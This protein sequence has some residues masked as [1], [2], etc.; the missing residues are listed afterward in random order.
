MP[1]SQSQAITIAREWLISDGKIS[2]SGCDDVAIDEAPSWHISFP[3]PIPGR[4]GGEPHVLVNKSDG[5]ITQVYYT[6]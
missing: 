2:L 6:Q 3:K 1:V 5:V 4:R